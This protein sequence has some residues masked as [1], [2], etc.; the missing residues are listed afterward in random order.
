M[1]ESAVSHT[2][3]PVQYPSTFSDE[4]IEHCRQ[5]CI[6]PEV[7]ADAR[8][9]LTEEVRRRY[10]RVN[11]RC[12]TQV[13]DDGAE[14]V[15]RLGTLSSLPDDS[16]PLTSEERQLGC[17][18]QLH[19][20]SE[21]PSGHAKNES[22]MLSSSAF[23]KAHIITAVPK[24]TL[25]RL[26]VAHLTGLPLA[27][28]QSVPWLPCGVLTLPWS[29]PIGG[30]LLFRDGV[31]VA[32]D[33]ASIAAVVALRPRRGERVLDL[34]CAPGMK[35]G[36]IADAVS[37]Q[38][39]EGEKDLPRG[40]RG[41]AV[42]VDVSLLRV[43][44]CRSTL[45][46]HQCGTGARTSSCAATSLPVCVFVGDGRYFTMA[47][48]M[49]SMDEAETATVDVGVG[50]TARER[51]ALRRLSES[52]TKRRR[53]DADMAPAAAVQRLVSPLRASGS[54]AGAVHVGYAPAEARASL[55]VWRQE[56]ENIEAHEQGGVAEKCLFDRVLVDAECSHDG[57]VAHLQL[58]DSK[59]P[60][61]IGNSSAVIEKGRG[62]T[63]KY[64]MQRLNLS[65]DG[66]PP[67]EA[68]DSSSSLF[69]LQ[70]E[71]L[72]NGYQQLKPG[73]TL[74]YSTCSY[75]FS[76]NELVVRRFLSRVNAPA[77]RAT[78]SVKVKAV[79]VPAFSYTHEG[80]GTP[81]RECVENAPVSSCVRMES[82]SAAEALQQQ[83]NDHAAD[84][85]VVEEGMRRHYPPAEAGPL[86]ST[87][88]GSRFWP[89]TFSSSFLYVAKV[90]KKVEASD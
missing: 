14:G 65:V 45:K 4:L 27:S 79:L 42:G 51:R 70:S 15:L 43:Y 84:Y 48:A 59:A 58:E 9:L 46:K 5:G 3:P 26:G 62:L 75:A 66:T 44:M 19:L 57:S 30:S 25:L 16:S 56:E 32:M 54:S 18:A 77:A 22:P 73:G 28:V 69:D 40:G 36:L 74:V 64:R 21:S 86:T 80:R 39:G 50:L 38:E 63:N 24:S 72:Y 23:T 78:N 88:V 83:L 81:N 1:N 67:A 87:P 10:V 85:G 52:T 53:C 49:A 35:L 12:L 33:A 89:R 71:L 31:L 41:L 34:C 11:P 20:R 17:E 82:E 60:L 76:Q 2:S 7:F 90:W 6:P 37:S 47:D 8:A 68:S 55:S 29:Y 13:L 61:D